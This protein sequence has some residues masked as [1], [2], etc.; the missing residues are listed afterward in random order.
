ME[1]Q[2]DF[3]SSFNQEQIREICS[4]SAHHQK[5]KQLKINA[6]RFWFY[7]DDRI[8]PICKTCK[9][10]IVWL[11]INISIY[12]FWSDIRVVCSLAGCKFFKE[13]LLFVPYFQM[14]PFFSLN[15]AKVMRS[16]SKSTLYKTHTQ[17]SWNMSSTFFLLLAMYDV[18]QKRY[19]S[20]QSQF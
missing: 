8:F 5:E 19:P 15:M 14:F 13:D 10:K 2:L 9:W 3:F 20:F 16:L 17:K 1:M 6:F 11:H 7:M 18:S 12:S 4:V